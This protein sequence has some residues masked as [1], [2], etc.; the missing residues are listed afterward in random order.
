[1]NTVL[2]KGIDLVK[3]FSFKIALSN[4]IGYCL[5]VAFP[6]YVDP[7][8]TSHMKYH[9]RIY[10]LGYYIC[11][12]SII[13]FFLSIIL[14]KRSLNWRHK[15][16]W[17][18]IILLL[19]GSLSMFN[20]KPEFPHLGVS[21][22]I[23][24]Y[25]FLSLFSSWIH[26]KPFD[27]AWLKDNI[28]PLLKLERVKELVTIWRTMAISISLGYVSIMLTAAKVMWESPAQF[29]QDEGEQFL[30]GCVNITAVAC[31]SIYLVFILMFETFKKAG[32]AADLILQ[33]DMKKNYDHSG[34]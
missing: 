7:R 9:H 4:S 21:L 12:F 15:M 5:T 28:D 22:G 14:A 26:Y 24:G 17:P 13:V 25:F 20:F 32:S 2:G 34:T 10:P 3:S 29:I 1:M 23:S 30:L 11:L 27:V 33:I 31:L 6:T 8:L 18:S 19:A 16:L